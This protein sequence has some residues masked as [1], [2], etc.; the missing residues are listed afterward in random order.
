MLV[1][2]FLALPILAQA[3]DLDDLCW[4][5][6]FTQADP[7]TSQPKWLSSSSPTA[8]V[9][10]DGTEICFTVNEPGLGMKWSAPLPA[11]SLTE[12]PYLVL[13]YRA[14]NLN[15]ASTDYLLHLDDQDPGHQL[16]AIRLCDA[17]ADGQWHTA[18]VDMS[19]LT[20]ADAV[21]A[22]AVQVQA[23]RQGKGRLWLQWLSFRDDP[24]EDATI[25]QRVPAAPSKPDWTAPLASMKWNPRNTWLSD[26]ADDGTFRVEQA[27]DRVLFRVNEPSRGMKWSADLPESF[28]LEGHRYL[29]I[30]YRARQLSRHGDYT[31]CGL[32]KPRPGG[33]SFLPVV[34][35]VEL[36][37]D[38][39]WHTLD[40]DVRRVAKQLPLITGIAMQ[41]QAAGPEASLQVS[42]IRL[43]NARQSSRLA[44]ALD[45]HPGATW[46]GFQPVP[47]GTVAAG[48]SDRWFSYLRLVDW[49]IGN[50]TDARGT[51]NRPSVTVE[52]VPFELLGRMPNLAVTA[53]RSK[54]QLRLPV[55]RTA[56]EVYMVLLAAMTGP[57]EPTYGSGP[58]R[59]IEDVDRFCLRLEY[60]DG[61]VDECLPMNVSTG[62][63]GVVSG[64]Q[65]LVAAADRMRRLEAVV[66][67]DRTR[68]AAFGVAA[69]TIRTDGTSRHPEA[70]EIT[71]P[72]R[73]KPSGTSPR[74]DVLEA[75]LAAGGPPT[76]EQL[77]HRPSG[78]RY[79][80]GPCP[81]VELHVDGKSIP[82]SDLEPVPA[83]KGQPGIRWYRVRSVKGLQLGLDVKAE[84]GDSLRI[85]AQVKNGSGQNHRTTL[86]VPSLSYR[87][88]ERP[89][90]AFY[91]M[92]KRGA[93]MNC[94]D[95]SYHERYCGTFPVQFV[96]TF[97]PSGGRGL[98]LRTED[99]QCVRKHYVLKK[100]ASTFT[101]GVEY[102]EQTLGPDEQ[103][104]TPPAIL[105]ATDGDWHRGLES[106]RRWL[107]TWYRPQTPR[108]PW[109]REVFNFRQRFLWGARPTLRRPPGE[110]PV[111][112]GYRG[113]PARVRAASNYLHLFDWGNCGPYGRIYGRTGDYS[114]Y[115]YLQGGRE[116]LRKAIAAVQVPGACRSACISKATCWT[117]AGSWASNSAA[118]GRRS[119]RRAKAGT[120][121]KAARW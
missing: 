49:F 108:Q 40:V 54:V 113:G 58:L 80:A 8:S 107:G 62:R 7:W 57:E 30:R 63:F 48:R 84:G 103:F 53:L 100:Q 35:C 27:A 4:T 72:L 31:L 2:M 33:P 25:I 115:D 17:H 121:R 76:I 82:V 112:P 42:D 96:D 47:I 102:P 34:S 3:G 70:T 109:F 51:G 74:R 9:T 117:N 110:A 20:S 32:G 14:E 79:L 52:G 104:Q 75:T 119:A 95:C 106:Y 13:R 90:D 118:A 59:A 77:V 50:G 99:T 114:P 11:V 85:T 91:L 26:P 5:Q 10:S 44:D 38:G 1:V 68:Q 105:T 22:M 69:I 18:A 56:S 64:P 24:P 94:R 29:S 60:A 87:L 111:G 92:P 55:G 23:N 15:I 83:T 19:T 43:V 39:H 46:Q 61:T 67:C 78:W 93:A 97:S 41:V 120:G 73:V 88:A 116:A 86:R 66:L 65:V 16:H 28:S 36:I 6:Q 98:S 12:Q 81:L 101:L 71:P 89:D 37:D 21:V 45:W